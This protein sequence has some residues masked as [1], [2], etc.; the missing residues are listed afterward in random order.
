MKLTTYNLN[1]SEI[2]A[3]S[4]DEDLVLL[5][6]NSGVYFRVAERAKAFLAKVME[7]TPPAAIIAALSKQDAAAGEE[8]GTFFE[9]L[10][11][12]NILTEAPFTLQTAPNALEMDALLATGNSFIFEGFDDLMDL[13]MADPVHDVDPA[14][15]Q[16][17]TS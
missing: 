16:L 7:G 10:K 13:V 4:F 12:N 8:A 2:M 9:I 14:T 3:E 6:I 5:N 15:A 11:Q 1:S 17:A